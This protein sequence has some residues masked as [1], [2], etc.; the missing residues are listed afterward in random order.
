MKFLSAP[1]V[2]EMRGSMGGITIAR[3]RFGQYMR[4]RVAPVQ[5]TSNRRSTVRAHFA[6]LAES[7][8]ELEAE[9]A[10]AWNEWAKT[11]NYTDSLGRAITLTGLNAY[12]AVNTLRLDAGLDRMDSVPPY[13]GFTQLPEGFSL[14]AEAGQRKL[15]ITFTAGIVRLNV[16]NNFLLVSVGRPLTQSVNYYRS[17]YVTIGK[18]IG[19]T[20]PPPTSPA[21]FDMPYEF[22]ADAKIP[23]KLRWAVSEGNFAIPKTEFVVAVD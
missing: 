12:M 4:N 3:N 14:S 10:S 19:K 2:G 13:P 9:S 7:F 1:L 15:L 16:D 5:P 11:L 8:R 18:I 20:T 22:Y 21:E 23:V 17:P 6:N